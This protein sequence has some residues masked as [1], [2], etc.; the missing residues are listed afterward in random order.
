MRWHKFLMSFSFIFGRCCGGK[1]TYASM[2]KINLPPRKIQNYLVKEINSMYTHMQITYILSYLRNWQKL[3]GATN[4]YCC[5]DYVETNIHLGK[6]LPVK[7][8]MLGLKYGTTVVITS[9]LQTCLEAKNMSFH[10][11]VLKQYGNR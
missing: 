2:W 4:Y 5:S 9:N 6:S 11:N 3:L 1:P 10:F 8:D 7:K